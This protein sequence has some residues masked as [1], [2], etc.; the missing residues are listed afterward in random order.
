MWRKF[1]KSKDPAIGTPTLIE[2]TFDQDYLD[3]IPEIDSLRSGH[4]SAGSPSLP[5]LSL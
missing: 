5:E 4:S 3:T 2:T 1:N